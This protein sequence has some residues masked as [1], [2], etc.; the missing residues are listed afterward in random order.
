[1]IDLLPWK[2]SWKTKLPSKCFIWMSL[3][4]AIPRDQ[5]LHVPQKLGVSELF[6]SAL[7][8]GKRSLE[9]VHLTNRYKLDS[10]P[11]CQRSSGSWRLKEVDNSIKKT[12]QMTRPCIFWCIWKERN[13]RCFDGISTPSSSLKSLS[14]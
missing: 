1:M 2:L 11:G 9:Y 7:S 13:V 6:V 4:N 5:M 10:S 3:R 12:W 8:S 14:F